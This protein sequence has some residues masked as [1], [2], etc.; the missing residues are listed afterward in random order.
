MQEEK[1]ISIIH[2]SKE[3][4]EESELNFMDSLETLLPLFDEIMSRVA[5]DQEYVK[6]NRENLEAFQKVHSEVLAKAEDVMNRKKELTVKQL[7]TAKGVKAYLD[8]YPRRIS[9]FGKR[10]G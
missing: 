10:K 9:A 7:N 8:K 3:A 5:V 2:L 6:E 4:I 1:L